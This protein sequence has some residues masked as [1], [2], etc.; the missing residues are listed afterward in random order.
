MVSVLFQPY[1][2][3]VQKKKHIFKKILKIQK[4]FTQIGQEMYLH[5]FR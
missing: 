1:K 2:H 5:N 4:I 3:F